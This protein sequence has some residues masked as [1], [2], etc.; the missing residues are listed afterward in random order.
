MFGYFATWGV[1]GPLWCD[2]S[3]VVMPRPTT[4]LHCPLKAHK[5]LGTP[6]QFYGHVITVR[7][8]F[9][10]PTGLIFAI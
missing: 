9:K 7:Q 1:V 8:P 10:L 4:H 5:A 2:A 6:L 3:R